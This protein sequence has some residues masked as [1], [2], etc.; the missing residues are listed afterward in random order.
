M[1]N[2]VVGH[3]IP[4]VAGVVRDGILPGYFGY[5]TGQAAVGDAF[6]WVARLTGKSHEEL[7]SEAALLAP[8]SGGVL[9]IDWLNG[10]RTPLMDGLLTGA[11]FGLRLGTQPAQ[12]YRAMMEATAFGLRT[13]VNLLRDGGVPITRFVASG[14]LPA[15]SPLLMQIYAD[16]LNADIELAGT[17]QSVALGAAILGAL[18]SR[19]TTVQAEE[20][21][22]II[23]A[24]TRSRD[25]K[26]YHPNPHS[27]VIY[28]TL[29]DQ[30]HSLTTSGSIACTAAEPTTVD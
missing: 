23:K 29:Y 30:Y 12:I 3:E 8:G 2:S 16:V 19:P 5:E 18:A 24:M 14:G 7:N 6:A 13:I 10:C 28:Q 22:Q 27:A 17:D 21:Q 9:A 15:R 4:G 11:L 1:I 26:S 25:E 20:M